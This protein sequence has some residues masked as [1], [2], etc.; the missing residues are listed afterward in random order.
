[1][2]KYN[3]NNNILRSLA[4][5]IINVQIILLSGTEPHTLIIIYIHMLSI[6]LD[7]GVAY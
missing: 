2:N 3:T 5:N 7:F 4:Y 6:L 1:M